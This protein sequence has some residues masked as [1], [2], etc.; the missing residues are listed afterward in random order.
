MRNMTVF[1]DFK[2]AKKGISAVFFI[3]VVTFTT[4]LQRFA[5]N[6]NRIS[7]TPLSIL[8]KCVWVTFIH[9]M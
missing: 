5:L 6:L 8:L 4:W 7:S 9:L 3:V 2:R 1:A